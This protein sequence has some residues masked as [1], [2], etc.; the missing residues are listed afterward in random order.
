MPGSPLRYQAVTPQ[1]VRDGAGRWY[2]AVATIQEHMVQFAPTP[3]WM[4]STQFDERLRN[5][6]IGACG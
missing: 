2:V 1:D 4:G 3:A 5:A 6:F